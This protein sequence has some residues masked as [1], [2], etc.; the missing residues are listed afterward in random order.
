MAVALVAAT[1]A[2]SDPFQ[3]IEEV[4][5]DPSL[6]IDLAT[7]TLLPS[8]VYIEDMPAGTGDAIT[9][10]STVTVNYTGWLIDATMFDTQQSAEFTV[11]SGALIEG[12][13][14]G[15]LG[16]QVG[17]T[18]RMII[19][20]ELGYGEAGRGAVPGGA[21]MIFEVELLAVS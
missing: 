12:F 1:A 3:V 2:C 8:G 17:G 9:L 5:F 19:P 20:P 18:R 11:V 14:D 21:I 13:V 16:M 7:M 15:L 10:G 4:V 6:G